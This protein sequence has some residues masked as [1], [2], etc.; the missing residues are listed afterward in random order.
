MLSAFVI[1]FSSSILLLIVVAWWQVVLL[2][3]LWAAGIDKNE[4]EESYQV[5]LVGFLHN[6]AKWEELDIEVCNLAIKQ[7]D[8][9]VRAALES[10]MT[11][12]YY[13]RKF[14][15]F[16]EGFLRYGCSGC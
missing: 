14:N 10:I 5:L 12:Y 11:H 16:I 4:I 2:R 15:K 13:R 7:D 1:G 3:A 9:V 6:E 8:I